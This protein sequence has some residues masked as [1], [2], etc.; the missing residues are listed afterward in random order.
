MGIFDPLGAFKK[1][2]SDINIAFPTKPQPLDY[3]RKLGISDETILT[4]QSQWQRV[5]HGPQ[6]KFI[7]QLTGATRIMEFIGSDAFRVSVSAHEHL[8][9]EAT[10]IHPTLGMYTVPISLKSGENWSKLRQDRQLASAIKK[11]DKSVENGSQIVRDSIIK[12]NW[13]I[14]TYV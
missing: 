10:I 12:I 14:T 6:L 13:Y 8:R 2:F 9:G 5:R 4:L 7:V 1:F 11:A 3:W